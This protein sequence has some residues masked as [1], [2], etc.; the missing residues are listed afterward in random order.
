MIESALHPFVML[1]VVLGVVLAS[2]EV[3]DWESCPPSVQGDGNR[4]PLMPNLGGGG[5][6][7]GPLD[8]AD[9]L[10]PSPSAAAA[11]PPPPPPPP[12]LPGAPAAQ[13]AAR[14]P[15][16]A[17]LR[18]C[19]VEQLDFVVVSEPAWRRLQGW[20]GGGP[21]VA[22]RVV[23][24]AAPCAGGG[25]GG[26]RWARVALYPLLLEVVFKGSD[27]KE[28]AAALSIEPERNVLCGRPGAVVV[29]GGGGES[30]DSLL[31]GVRA[32][33]CQG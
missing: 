21:A 28:R 30:R 4:G 10:S 18:P 2:G 14:P 1:N 31:E 20:Y 26:G 24:D 33:A 3:G 27:G 8:N 11:A 17:P 23:A 16:A 29:M 15:D 13:P 19:L 32:F 9:L 7:P 25:G 5:P 22:R 12:A 6:R